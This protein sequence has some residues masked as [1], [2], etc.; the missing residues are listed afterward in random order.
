MLLNSEREWDI[1][2]MTERERETVWERRVMYPNV[3]LP[4]VD[5][6]LSMSLGAKVI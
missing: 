2:E 5:E 3:F 1:C 4:K 6:I